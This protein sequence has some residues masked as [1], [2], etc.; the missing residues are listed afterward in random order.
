MKT[1][2]Y[3][4]ALPEFYV[5]SHILDEQHEPFGIHRDP[6]VAWHF[7]NDEGPIPVTLQGALIHFQVAIILPSG[8]VECGDCS[9]N[10]LQDWSETIYPG[11]VLK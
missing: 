1:H 2:Y 5:A 10:N 9:F 4:P 6:I 8:A 7:E 3:V 11:W